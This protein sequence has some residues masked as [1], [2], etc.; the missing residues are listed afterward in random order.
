M[1]IEESAD[2]HKSCGVSGFGRAAEVGCDRDHTRRVPPADCTRHRI[3]R[4]LPP[5]RF[6]TRA[7]FGEIAQRLQSKRSKVAVIPSSKKT[8]LRFKPI[9]MR[10]KPKGRP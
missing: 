3:L 8:M 2:R 6:G 5:R 4:G 9:A 7:P 10:R 1:T